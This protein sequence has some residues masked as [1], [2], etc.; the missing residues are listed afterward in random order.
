MHKA[1]AGRYVIGPDEGER[2][3]LGGL[4]VRFL[5]DSEQTGGRFSLVEHPIAPRSLAAPLHT[6][7]AVDE[8][9]FVL[10]GEVGVQVGDDVF[11]ATPGQLVVKPRGIPHAFWNATDEE[12]SVLEIISP[13]GLEH[14]FRALPSLIRPD[15]TPTDPERLG[16]M[17]AEQ[18]LDLDIASA[19]EL[20]Q[21]YGLRQ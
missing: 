13:G 15:G 18:Q 11:T 1:T 5:L 12:A 6:H 9:S 3:D 21:R 8:Y 10:V 14:Y 2:V 16:R 4:G 20:M 19:P 7:A 17:L